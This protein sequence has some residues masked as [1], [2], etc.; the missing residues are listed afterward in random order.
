MIHYIPAATFS[1]WL[2]VIVVQLAVAI[3]A[4]M[5]GIHARYPAFASLVYV[6]AA[7]SCILLAISI[8]GTQRA[9]LYAFTGMSLVTEVCMGLLVRELYVVT[10]GPPESL[11]RFIQRNV[12]IVAP[13]TIGSGIVLA[14]LAKVF[15]VIALL[16][17]LDR[18]E[19][20]TLFSLCIVLWWM[21]VYS[22]RVG[23]SWRN[24]PSRVAAGFLI[25]LTINSVSMAA[26]GLPG[27]GP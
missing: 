26:R 17:V 16:R 8:F 27:Q 2:A 13:T 1:V 9:Y 12:S 19:K 4:A 15:G 3:M 25:T 18:F 23:I 6:L 10:F 22:R 20:M 21:V 14:L 5:R 11:P 24:L 7:K